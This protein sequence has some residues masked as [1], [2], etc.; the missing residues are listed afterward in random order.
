MKGKSQLIVKRV[1]IIQTNNNYDLFQIETS[2]KII[3]NTLSSDE[4]GS[5]QLV[6]NMVMRLNE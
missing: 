1:S 3:I 5:A 2:F 4:W 6:Y